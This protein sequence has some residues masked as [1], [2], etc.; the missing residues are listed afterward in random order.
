M[1]LQYVLKSKSITLHPGFHRCTVRGSP[2]ILTAA[3]FRIL[4]RL[5]S[6]PRW[7]FS[8]KELIHAAHGP[9]YPATL[10]T[11]DIK[12]H[13]LRQKLGRDVIESVYGVGYRFAEAPIVRVKLTS[14]KSLHE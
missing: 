8:R 2:R 3:E 12:V 11:I 14:R 10:K 4:Y 6:R 1:K 13:S 9:N 7:V 5:M